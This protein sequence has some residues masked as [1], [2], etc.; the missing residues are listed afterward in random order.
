M[1]LDVGGGG[2]RLEGERQW[3]GGGRPVSI[4]EGGEGRFVAE[5][6]GGGEGRLLCVGLVG[7]EGRGTAMP[8]VD[9]LMQNNRK[10]VMI[11]K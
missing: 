9:L 3:G 11:S 1:L 5:T 4:K 2:G 8:W 6:G 7:T 10:E